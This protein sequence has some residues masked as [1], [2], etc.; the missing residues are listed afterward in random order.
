MTLSIKK[1]IND[2]K[3]KGSQEFFKK[4]SLLFK[5]ISNIKFIKNRLIYTLPAFILLI[6]LYIIKFFINIRLGLIHRRLGHFALNTELY[7]LE[8]KYL[9]NKQYIDIWF[10]PETIPNKQIYKM[11]KRKIFVLSLG[12]NFVKEVKNILELFSI[13]KNLIIGSNTQQDRDIN[14]LLDRSKTQISLTN[15]ELEAGRKALIE[16]GINERLPI[17]CLLI[18]DNA[19]LNHVYPGDYDWTSQDFRDSSVE[20]YYKVASYLANNGYQVIRMGKIVKDRF[21]LDHPL[22]FDYANSIFR[23]DFMDVYIGYKC[24]FTISN[25]TGWDAIPVIFRKPILFVNHAPIINIHTYSKKYIHIF[26]H[27]YDVKKK[28]YLKIE[29]LV[30]AGM[31]DLYET[32]YFKNNNIKLIENTPDEILNATKEMLDLIS[33]NF[34][35]DNEKI[36]NLIWKQFPTNYINKYNNNKMHGKIKS[37]FSSSFISKNKYLLRDD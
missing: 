30:K 36:Q 31:H 12:Y 3:E 6:I 29:D 18:R 1:Q 32:F 20:N 9:E 13:N 33:N 35:K 22:I 23:S 5:K 2:I 14:N 17:V 34:I 15:T 27:H 4:F 10:A 11:I 7:L 25:S 19:Y 16:M 28:K 21:D 26:K 37:R 24:L 8:K